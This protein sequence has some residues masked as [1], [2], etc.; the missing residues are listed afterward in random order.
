MIYSF[1]EVAGKEFKTEGHRAVVVRPN[2]FAVLTEKS[3]QDFLLTTHTNVC[4]GLALISEDKTCCALVHVYSDGSYYQEGRE[5][6]E[7]HGVNAWEKLNA[8]LRIHGEQDEVFEAVAFGS[9]DHLPPDFPE[10]H[11]RLSVSAWLGDAFFDAVTKSGRLTSC[12]NLRYEDVPHDAL[13]D[14]RH[15]DIF[16]GRTEKDSLFKDPYEQ[17]YKEATP[18]FP[19]FGISK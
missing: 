1:S 5:A 10:A 12:K 7:R 3:E 2:H 19:D 8:A 13:I 15:G 18:L 11:E 17:G 4:A 6:V 16:I 14:F 9:R